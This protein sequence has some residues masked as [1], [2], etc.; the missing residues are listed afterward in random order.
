MDE[1]LVKSIYRTPRTPNALKRRNQKQRH[2]VLEKMRQEKK[3]KDKRRI[4][5]TYA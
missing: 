5:D 3:K 2:A 1:P 4:I